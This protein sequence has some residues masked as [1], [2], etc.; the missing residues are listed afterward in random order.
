[1][2]HRDL[3]PLNVLLSNEWVAQIGPP[4]ALSLLCFLPAPADF[5]LA[6]TEE[7]LQASLQAS[8]YHDEEDAEGRAKPTAPGASQPSG[9]FGRQHMVGTL[10]YTAP[11]VLMRRVASFP[12]D[13]YSL[14]ILLCELATA[15]PPYADRARNVA[16][17]HTVLDL[18][19]NERDLAIAIASEGLR[20]AQPA[21]APTGL[22]QLL[23]ACWAPSAAERPAA[24]AV[25][26]S[27]A[28]LCDAYKESEALEKLLPLWRTP[29]PPPPPPPPAEL[30]QLLC[31][32]GDPTLPPA[33]PVGPGPPPCVTA[34]A[35]S[36]AGRRGAD[37]MED[38]LLLLSPL[39]GGGE[40]AHLL[41]V[42]DG[43]RGAEAAQFASKALPRALAAAWGAPG[44]QPQQS[45][46]DAFSSVDDA[47]RAVDDSRRASAS[48]ADA[49]AQPRYPGSTAVAVLLWG[50]AVYTANAGDCRAVLVR[51]GSA[52][53][54]SRDH[55][56]EDAAERR[57]CEACGGRF[58]RDAAGK[59]RLGDAGV[60]VTRGF[61][62][63][64]VKEGGLT[65]VPEVSRVELCEEDDFLIVA[66]DGL[67]D[68]LGEAEAAELVAST[69]KEPGM[70]AKRLVAEAM[71][72]GSG[73]NITVIVAF[74]REGLG[75]G[76]AESVWRAVDAVDR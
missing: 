19:Y 75:R 17:A 51:G 64:D 67:W 58:A 57:R 37:K 40:H 2:V 69:V 76:E 8:I 72:R 16:L 56:A 27:L 5:G 62:D 26:D 4:L 70:A 71:T 60:A 11:E 28:A 65:A 21:S 74:L 44:A 48:A 29:P 59:W 68:V 43:H 14:G 66:C 54:L 55:T 41:C 36:L 63:F 30:D 47:F 39:P 35:L 9:G 45:L 22:A 33:W 42:F 13:V 10:A 25:V 1:V 6:E 31:R 73:D 3:K 23:E 18:S 50:D 32:G 52:C 61:G 12:A 15:T 34:G 24:S 7:V 49:A 53:A 38:R 46:A 20:P